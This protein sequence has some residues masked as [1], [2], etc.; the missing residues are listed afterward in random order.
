MRIYIKN[1]R[2]SV[3]AIRPETIATAFPHQS[4]VLYTGLNNV[5]YGRYFGDIGGSGTSGHS[6]SLYAGIVANRNEKKTWTIIYDGKIT[7]NSGATSDTFNFGITISK[8]RSILGITGTVSYIG[9]TY[10]P[11]NSSGQL[12]GIGDHGYGNTYDFHSD[13]DRIR[14]ARYH[15]TNGNFGSWPATLNSFA[16]NNIIFGILILQES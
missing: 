13:Q 5:K 3:F 12:A 10:F 1:N 7:Q 8:L 11:F 6:F 15:E 14:F 9:G 4:R 16:T 2:N